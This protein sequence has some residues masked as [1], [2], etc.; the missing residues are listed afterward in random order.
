ME[1]KEFLVEVYGGTAASCCWGCSS[2]AC[3]Q[4]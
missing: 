4:L 3:G 2:T 1:A